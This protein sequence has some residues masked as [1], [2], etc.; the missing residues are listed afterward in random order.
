M[1]DVAEEVPSRVSGVV[2]VGQLARDL[3]LRVDGLPDVG[4]AAQVT[5]RRE[6]LGGKGANCAVAVAQLGAPSGLIAV[7]GDDPVADDVLD[8]ARAS[9]VDCSAVVR[10][11]GT[12]TGLIVEC[13]EAGGRW[14][15]LEDLPEP[16]LVGPGDVTRA[17]G[18][19]S[20]DTVVLQAQ[21]PSETLLDAARTASGSGATTVLDGAPG[22]AHRD[23]LLALVDVLRADPAEA[24]LLVGDQPDDAPSALAAARE[25]R[26]RGPRLVVLGAEG[27]GNVAVWDGGERTEPLA[28]VDVVDTTGGGDAM[29]A[30]LAVALR[31]GHGPARALRAGAAAAADTVGHPGGRPSLTSALLDP[32]HG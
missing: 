18:L 2:V 19:R 16:V 11:P 23:E 28:D 20:A 26:R 32:P 9:G 5:G 8:Q 14:R 3:V 13:L 10:R 7:A 12:S 30:A 27:A 29:T 22:C 15:Y 25:L 1:I 6:M 4:S 21:Q 24:G 31:A 17:D